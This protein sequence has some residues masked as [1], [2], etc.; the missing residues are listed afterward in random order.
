MK[1]STLLALTASALALPGLY[2]VARADSPPAATTLSYR[3]SSYQEDDLDAAKVIGGS[4]Q[5]YDITVNQLQLIKPIADKYSLTL[6]GSTDSMSGASPWYAISQ[7]NGGAGIVMSGAT[8]HEERRDVNASVRRYLDNGTV[9]V[10]LGYSDENDYEALSGGVDYERHFNDNLTTIAG[11]F[12]FSSDDLSPTDAV[13]FNRVLDASKQS[14]SAFIALTQVINQNSLVQTGLSLTHVSGYLS[15]PYKLFDIRPDSRSQVAWTTAWRQFIPVANAALH[16]NYR[17][18]HDNYGINSHTAELSWY[19]NLGKDWQLVPGVRY[20]TQSSA[21][22]FTPASVFGS[23]TPTSADYRLSAYGAV[24][25]S[26]KAQVTIQKFKFSLSGERYRSNESLG[27]FDDAS[28]PALVS[29]TRWSL[30][31]DYEF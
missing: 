15:D 16:A 29:F 27:V 3:A 9:G 11:G 1:S 19:Q 26:L 8:I 30:G 28:S 24:S 4:K 23:T 10:A 13:S 7:A 6:T 5:R 20:Y 18:Y 17:Y 14:R 12:S 25:G 21:D 22:F 2:P 31:V